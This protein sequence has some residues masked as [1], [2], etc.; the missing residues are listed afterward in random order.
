MRLI[1]LW[2]ERSIMKKSLSLVSAAAF[3]AICTVGCGA[4]ANTVHTVDDLNGKKIGTQLGTTGYIFAGDVEGA[5]VEG[6]DNGEDAIEALK[7]GKID[8][9]IIDSEPAHEFVKKNKGIQILSDVF[10]EEEYSIAYR[11]DNTEL[12]EKIDEALTELK[13][14]GTLARIERNWIGNNPS[15]VSFKPDMNI[16]RSGALI[17]ATNAEFPPYESEMNGEIVGIDID[18]MRAVCDEL[19][20][21]LKIENM[22]FDSILD[23]VKSGKA[24]VGV[25]GISVT[26]EREQEVNFTQSYATST[27]V[28]ITRKDKK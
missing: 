6:F 20:Y 8:A 26:P 10:A 1:L 23:A 24:D 12:G 7:K 4:P 2:K 17:M 18:I 9:V 5:T 28:I 3:F 19:G 21:T 13:Y 22:D 11:K 27:Q 15:Q 16:E 25:A 14:D